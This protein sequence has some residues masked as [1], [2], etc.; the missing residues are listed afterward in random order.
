MTA[1]TK[2]S[3]LFLPGVKYVSSTVAA[4]STL[5]PVRSI[6]GKLRLCFVL[7]YAGEIA[8][9][10]R[11]GRRGAGREAAA[12]ERAALHSQRLSASPALAAEHPNKQNQTL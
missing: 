7:F 2:T 10:V 4:H 6:Y 3:P 9:K 8:R 11:W 12:Q 5:G 1:R